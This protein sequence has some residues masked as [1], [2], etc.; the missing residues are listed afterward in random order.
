[1]EK[2]SGV[3]YVIAGNFHWSPPAGTLGAIVAEAELR[4]AALVAHSESFGNA[5]SARPIA[6]SLAAAL[7]QPTVSL[8]AEVKRQSPSKGVIA[9]SLDAVEQVAA[10]RDGGAAGVSILTEP[11]HFGGSIGDLRDVVRSGR[12][13]VLKKDFH[14]APAQLHEAWA[15][16]ASAAL[17]IV[18]AV[19]PE[20]LK[21]LAA[22]GRSLDLELLFEIRDERELEQ[23]LDA[24]AIMIGVNNRNLET[25]VIDPGTAERLIPLIPA[26]IVAIAESGVNTRA[27]VERYAAVGADAVLVGSSLSA[28]VDPVA[29]TRALTGV[30]RRARAG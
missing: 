4:A 14:V 22:Y 5:V 2:P 26:H 8:L 3:K 24:E 25:L 15:E 28:S 13:P 9:A 18:R 29:A 10:Y 27:D 6:P 12:L 21:E 30:P 17:L 1:M 20:V 16:G 23:A 11:N 7:R 19:S